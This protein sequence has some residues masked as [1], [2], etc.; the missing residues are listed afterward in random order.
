MSV[1]LDPGPI[2]EW[3]FGPTNEAQER[4]R[5][6]SLTDE[7]IAQAKKEADATFIHHLSIHQLSYKLM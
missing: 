1:S 6:E 3:A 7:A 2:T 5:V 4:D